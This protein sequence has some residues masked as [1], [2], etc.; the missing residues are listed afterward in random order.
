MCQ[1]FGFGNSWDAS[2]GGYHHRQ[3]VCQPFGLEKVQRLGESPKAWGTHK[4]LRK[5]Q[6]LWL[7]ARRADTTSAGVEGPGS[8]AP[9]TAAGPEGRYT[10]DLVARQYHAKHLGCVSPSGLAVHRGL[11][12]V[13]TTTGRGYASPSGLRKCKDIHL[14]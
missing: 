10:L 6:R 2:T 12:P 3:R 13:V 11:K 14:A 9:P 7:L 1:P 8:H 4:G 5:A